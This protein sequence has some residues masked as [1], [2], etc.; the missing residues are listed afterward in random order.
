M[1]REILRFLKE[2]TAAKEQVFSQGRQRNDGGR[3]SGRGKEGIKKKV[4]IRKRS[5]KD[6]YTLIAWGGGRGG[7]GL[8][9][10][11]ASEEYR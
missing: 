11:L 3:T 4:R 6:W 9:L 1:G 7:G 8:Q 5:W 10:G 2:L